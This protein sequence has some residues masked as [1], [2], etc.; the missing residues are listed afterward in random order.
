MVQDILA[1]ESQVNSHTRLLSL[2]ILKNSTA[3]TSLSDTSKLPSNASI[4]TSTFNAYP[5]TFDLTEQMSNNFKPVPCTNNVS[6]NTTLI[7]NN[8][9]KIGVASL[10]S[11]KTKHNPNCIC[12]PV[13]N[14]DSLISYISFCSALLLCLMIN[15]FHPFNHNETNT[16]RRKE[17]VMSNVY[18]EWHPAQKDLKAL[19]LKNTNRIIV[20][21]LNINSIRN[22]FEDLINLITPYVDILLVSE[23]KIDASFPLKQFFIEGYFPPYRLDR[24]INGGGLLLYIREHIPSK[25]LKTT[26]TKEGLLIEINLKKKKWLLFG[27]YNSNKCF[28]KDY[29]SEISTHL[30]TLITDYENLIIMGDFNSELTET[31]M[32]DFCNTYDLSNLI[33]DATCYKNPNNPSCIDLI[34]TNKN[35]LFQHSNALETGLSDFHKLTVSVLKMTYKKLKPKVIMYRNYKNYISEEFRHDFQTQF[36]SPNNKPSYETFENIFLSVLNKYAPVKRKYLRG[37][38]QPFMNK[39]LSKAIMKRSRLRNIYIKHRSLSNRENYVRQR[40]F[41]TNLLRRTKRD[42]YSNLDINN[43]TDNK[44]FW[45]SIKPCFTDKINTNEQITLVEK[46]KILTDDSEIAETMNNFFINVVEMLEIPENN[47]ILMDTRGI[48]DPVTKAIVKYSIHPSIIKINESHKKNNTLLLYHTTVNTIKDRILD[49]DIKKS[50]SQESIPSKLLKENYDIISPI[51]CKDFNDGLDNNKFPDMLKLAEI[52]PNFKKADHCLKENYRPISLLP[53]VSKIYEK[54]LHEQISI[55]F[56]TIMS[57]L[58]CGFRKGHN[59]QNSLLVLLEKWR[60]SLDTK[61]KAGMLL[62]DLSKAFDCIRHDLFIAK[63]HAYGVDLKSLRYIYDYLTN[64][65]QRVRINNNFSTW[66]NIIYGVP[67]GSILGPLFF[68]IYITDLFLTTDKFNLINYADDNTPYACESTTEK[69]IH[70]LQKCTELLFE[71]T[72]LNFLKAN[73]DKSH[74]VLSDAGNRIIKIKTEQIRSSPSQKLLGITIENG[75]R[76]DTHVK[77]LC[78]K[79]NLKLHALS[80]ISTYM[81]SSKLKIIMKA[82]ILSQFN[83]CPLVWMFHSRECNNSINRIHERA[84]RLAYR[85]KTSSFQNLLN[86]DGSVLIHHK[87]LQALAI[88]IYKFLNDLSPKIMGEI[89]KRKDIVYGLRS[90]LVLKETN[91]NTVHYGEQSISHL[92]PRIWKLVPNDIRVSP[93]LKSFKSKIKYWT[94]I[95]CPCRLCKRYVQNVG[96]I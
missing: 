39:E 70:T 25:V 32:A 22:K 6:N 43:I 33:K 78:Q 49:I 5:R 95:N 9:S 89:F 67:Q 71:W 8:T 24:S 23:T 84:L 62:T 45:S 38:H 80:R 30:D 88:E 81:P 96:F 31:H 35:K 61:Q 57:P 13:N 77:N 76:F 19:R 12:D 40:N 82:F 85:D 50:S 56:E 1:D 34:L 28:I 29:L 83:Y 7:L 72:N 87:N 68:N 74:V 66:K 21:H 10:E 37:N 79:A 75:L 47:N 65:K 42:Y 93:T 73:P 18:R 92:A 86:K 90:Q 3:S 20:S 11:H 4:I 46:N 60:K 16:I 2:Q 59:A 94:P 54:I 41:C 51:L 69:V 14:V 58:Q 36:N 15:W 44:K 17:S 27:G 55:Y 26:F 53:S 91:I 63:C 52:K 48:N 64:R